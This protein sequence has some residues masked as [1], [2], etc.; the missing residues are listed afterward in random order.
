VSQR[1]VR[2]IRVRRPLVEVATFVTDPHQVLPVVPGL[3]R[4]AFVGERDGS[5]EWDVFL[6]I[7]TLHVGGRV[8]VKRPS[9]SHL[10]W[11]SDRGTRHRF[12]LEVE[13]D[14]DDASRVTMD[15]EYGLSGLLMA[16]IS[17]VLARGIVARHL[18]AGLEEVR[19][20]LEHGDVLP[21]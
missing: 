16:R 19:H 4:F 10:S 15:L 7:G 21:Q 9:A 11:Q 18:E 13:P 8:E 1:V 5:E 2:S 20:H 3:A 14:G 17:E 12:S 6:E